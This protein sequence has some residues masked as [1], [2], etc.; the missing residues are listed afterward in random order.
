MSRSI[1]TK[2]LISLCILATSSLLIAGGLEAG[3]AREGKTMDSKSNSK[4]NS[5]SKS[6]V[7][8]PSASRPAPPKVAP[9]DHE[10][11]RYENTWED[12]EYVYAYRFD[13][14]KPD[15]PTGKIL[16]K[17][18]VIDYRVDP[19]APTGGIQTFIKSMLLTDENSKL[20]I[21]DEV[22]GRYTLDLK[23]QKVAL[24]NWPVKLQYVASESTDKGWNYRVRLTLENQ[25]NR[26]LKLDEPSVGYGGKVGAP[27]ELSNQLF[28]VTVDGKEV[29][30]MGP[31]R[32][33]APPDKFFEL[34]SGESYSVDIELGE[35]YPIPSGTHDVVV[36]FEHTNHFSPD[37]FVMKSA[38]VRFRLEGP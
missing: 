5:K 10:G 19:Q 36:H 23:T 22:G 21:E 7:G 32:R 26:T 4:S 11:I 17:T 2:R 35:K 27:G 20:L 1:V 3:A 15:Q 38:P 13:P 25:L 12:R 9:V 29:R 6:S 28:T 34:K 31:L 18:K 37:G 8:A 33:R 24:L 16:W 30:Y 14:K